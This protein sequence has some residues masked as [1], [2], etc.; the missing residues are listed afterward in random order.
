[1]RRAAKDAAYKSN[2][3][4]FQIFNLNQLHKV[5]WTW[6]KK[7]NNNNS[8]TSNNNKSWSFTCKDKSLWQ[9]LFIY[10]YVLRTRSCSAFEFIVDVIGSIREFWFISRAR[11]PAP[12]GRGWLPPLTQRGCALI[13]CVQC[14][15]DATALLAALSLSLSF[16]LNPNTPA[17]MPPA[18]SCSRC[19]CRCSCRCR[20]GVANAARPNTQPAGQ[21]ASPFTMLVP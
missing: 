1:M 9:N 5:H 11:T 3:M 19:R 16:P 2:E 7:N 4:N 15:H 12:A 18:L 14:A 20:T 6:H 8:N 21:L 17:C 10:Q 13:T